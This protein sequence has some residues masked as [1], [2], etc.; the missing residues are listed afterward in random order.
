MKELSYIREY[1]NHQSPT[2]G[3]LWV[4]KNA[5]TEQRIWIKYRQQ[6]LRS[7]NATD[8]KTIPQEITRHRGVSKFFYGRW[9]Q[10]PLPSL[11]VG[12]YACAKPRPTQRE[13]PWIYGQVTDSPSLLSYNLD[14]DNHILRRNRT[15][16]RPAMAPTNF[17]EHP[18]LPPPL[19]NAS[20]SHSYG[21][22]EKK[23]LS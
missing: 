16:L 19:L 4:F 11:A 15:Q 21:F 10:H 14:T 5:W 1:G 18:P 9:T 13:E 12:S 7:Q 20:Q 6:K 8:L 23:M 17:P 22:S 2:G 3:W